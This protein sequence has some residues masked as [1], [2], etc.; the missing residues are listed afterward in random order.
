MERVEI[1]ETGVKPV[2]KAPVIIGFPEVGL[3]GSI[4]VSHTINTLGLAE[5]GYIDSE[6]FPPVVAVHGGRPKPPARIYANKK[7]VAITSEVPIPVQ[8]IRPLTRSLVQW[9]KKRE[10]SLVVILGGVA[11]P[12]RAGIET[13]KVY[14]VGVSEQGDKLLG[15][16]G[17]T[18]LEEGL[19]AGSHGMLL[20]GCGEAGVN[21]IYL[22]AEA[23]YG[24]PDPGAAASVVSICN[25]ML[26]LNIDTK[27]LL[28][29]EEQIRIAARDLM[30]RT[31][32]AMRDVRK[33]QEHEIPMMYG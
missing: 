3:V 28:E 10:T 22:M 4:A 32:Q 11:H 17:V 5:V 26:G 21:T 24:Y 12:E 6:Q 7:L 29:Q 19:L 2:P 25:K 8:S 18:R 14:G 15:E 1:V 13:P 23:H 20:W 9:F 27:P 16:H 31:E 30:R 33:E